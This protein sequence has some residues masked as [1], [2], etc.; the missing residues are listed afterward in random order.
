[1]AET[2]ALHT[3]FELVRATGARL[4]LCRLSS[5]KGVAL[6]RAKA[7]GLP[8]TADV[9]IN[10]LMLS[11]RDIGYFNSAFR[12]TPRCASPP[13]ATRCKPVSRTARSTPRQRPHARHRRREDI[14]LRRGHARR[15]G[16]GLLLGLAL[17]WGQDRPHAR[18]VAR[19]RH[20][21]AGARARPALGRWAKRWSPGG[22]AVWPTSASSTPPRPGLSRPP[23]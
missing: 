7:E 11:D 20:G 4:H 13:I 15:H 2:L 16:P 14:A 6:V 3:A 21:R 10:S 5:S 23:S 12:V 1:M 9:S 8:I 17:R 19:G 22:W 18:T